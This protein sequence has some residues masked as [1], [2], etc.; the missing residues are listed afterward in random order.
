MELGWR[1][2]AAVFDIV[3]RR[4]RPVWDERSAPQERRL[5]LVLAPGSRL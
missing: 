3:P 4:T 1:P 2:T 5:A